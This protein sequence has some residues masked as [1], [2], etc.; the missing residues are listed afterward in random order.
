MK[1]KRSPASRWWLV[2]ILTCSGLAAIA[3]LYLHVVVPWQERRLA[4][5]ARAFLQAGDYRNANLVARQA[6]QLNAGDTKAM[7]VL[8]DLEAAIQLPHAI[9]W[10]REIVKREP[11]NPRVQLLLAGT[12]LKFGETTIAAEALNRIQSRDSTDYLQ[13]AGALALAE[14]RLADAEAAFKRAVTLA[15]ENVQLRTSFA[16]LR[17][18]ATDAETV[19]DARTELQK[20]RELPETSLEATRDLL[21]DARRQGDSVRSMTLAQEL[22]RRPDA[23]V[24]DQLRPA[25]EYLCRK[26]STAETEI[27]RVRAF[28]QASANPAPI[29]D[30]LLWLNAAG[31]FNDTVAIGTREVPERISLVYPVCAAVADAYLGQRD[32]QGLRAWLNRTDW[33]VYQFLKLALEARILREKGDANV[34]D[35]WESALV[36]TRGDASALTML[37]RLADTWRWD[38]EAEQIWWLIA[39]RPEGQ[40]LALKALYGRYSRARRA[41]DLRRVVNRIFEVEPLNP[42]AKNNVASLGLLLDSD[43]QSSV[44]LLS[45]RKRTIF[46]SRAWVSFAPPMRSRSIAR[47]NFTRRLPSCSRC[48]RSYWNSRLSE[49]L[50]V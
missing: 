47:A 19:A 4:A 39:K 35:K 2:L 14:G 38:A 18:Q 25:E 31:R 13:L 30:F 50:T 27:T 41:D 36:A 9:T 17:L 29:F 37:A 1:L 40:R 5:S 11:D 48:R 20:L 7:E 32:F 43:V 15:P 28:V 6:L 23:S 16:A 8:A 3:W 26:D 10:R 45:W 21:Q 34:A 49:R 24:Q 33:D 44:E 42:I 46:N 12:A 22:A